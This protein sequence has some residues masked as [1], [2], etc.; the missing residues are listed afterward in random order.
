MKNRWPPF[1]GLSA[2]LLVVSL[3]PE[4]VL[5][6]T[7]GARYADASMVFVV[8]AFAAVLSPFN[9]QW[10]L[11]VEVMKNLKISF[12]INFISNILN[13]ILNI[14]LLDSMEQWGC[15]LLGDHIAFILLCWAILYKCSIRINVF[16]PYPVIDFYKSGF[17]RAI[18][19]IKRK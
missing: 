1:W 7:A 2:G 11:F 14:F 6:I 19:F 13:V 16:V 9:I 8:M 3:F 12:Y 15:L 5:T 4:W 10:G 17:F 18:D